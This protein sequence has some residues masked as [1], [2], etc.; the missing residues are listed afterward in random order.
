MRLP[1]PWLRCSG[2]TLAY[3][4]KGNPHSNVHIR[5]PTR[6]SSSVATSN[7]LARNLNSNVSVS[8]IDHSGAPSSRNACSIASR[9][10]MSSS[11]APRTT[12][13]VT[14]IDATLQMVLGIVLATHDRAHPCHTRLRLSSGRI[15]R[16]RRR[17]ATLGLVE[18]LRGRRLVGW[19]AHRTAVRRHRAHLDD[20]RPDGSGRGSRVRDADHRVLLDGP[21][22]GRN[23][24]DPASIAGQ[25]R[26]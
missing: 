24:V 21:A 9:P 16:R 4:T 17:G 25:D 15:L 10:L 26:G 12:R 14:A 6:R 11:V 22:D 13:L 23:P 3:S 8:M 7:D 1:I 20:P 5:Y 18:L 19:C 2:N